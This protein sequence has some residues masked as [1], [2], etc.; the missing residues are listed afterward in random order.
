MV[1]N[2]HPSHFMTKTDETFEIG[3]I[4][5][6]EN[7]GLIASSLHILNDGTFTIWPKHFYKLYTFHGTKNGH[8]V[9]FIFALLP[10]KKEHVKGMS[11][12][13]TI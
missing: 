9:P 6:K 7:I 2:E 8:C 4:S 11:G 5:T 1:L 3:V 10:D 13:D 12:K